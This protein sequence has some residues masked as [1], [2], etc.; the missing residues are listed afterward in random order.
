MSNL[1]V[2]VL[3]K[4]E[5]KNI[6]DVIKNAKLVTDNI[7]VVDSGSTDKTV[8]LAKINGANVVDR[9]WDNN[10]SAQRNFALEYVDTD[11]V[12]YLDADERMNVEL[13]NAVNKVVEEN[14]DRAFSFRRESIAFGKKFNY[15]VLCPDY[16]LRLL[17]KEHIFWDKQVHECVIHKCAE[18]KLPG[19]VEHFT[20]TDWHQ[21][22]TKFNQYTTLWAENAYKSGKRTSFIGAVGHA[23]YGFIKMAILKKGILDGWLGIVLA[24]N[25]FSYTLNKYVKLIDLQKR[26]GK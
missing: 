26:R 14:S 8:E 11:W 20:Y 22:F 13:V 10:F 21:Y 4:N 24:M 25:H 1:T 19:Y 12:L 3:T 16:V 18:S 9:A 7:L 17:K 2:V 6:V 5:E 15:G 23:V